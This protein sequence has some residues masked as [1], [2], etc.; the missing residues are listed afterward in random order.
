MTALDT[1]LDMKDQAS[2]I[3]ADC[4]CVAETE[5]IW[6]ESNAVPVCLKTKYCP[7]NS[8]CCINLDMIP[9]Q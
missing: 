6:N 9:S 3:S 5:D 2:Q 8:A 1:D 7:A 4:Q